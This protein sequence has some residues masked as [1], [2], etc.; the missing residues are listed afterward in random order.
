MDKRTDNL[1]IK[2]YHDCSSV[3]TNQDTQ[4]RPE[5]L[6]RLRLTQYSVKYY[7]PTLALH[8]CDD[9]DREYVSENGGERG[10][11]NSEVRVHASIQ[12]LKD[13]MRKRE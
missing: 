11:A 4:K 12:C 6:R 13:Y 2:E 7:Q 1:D 3:E 8:S 9:V 5:N 10:L